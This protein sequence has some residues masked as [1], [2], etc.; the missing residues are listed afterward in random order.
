VSL[1]RNLRR[2][3]HDIHAFAVFVEKNFSVLQRE[4]R[5]V[6]ARA[7]IRARLKFR[8][9]LAD[10]DAA[11]GHERAAKFFHAKPFADAIAPIADAA[12]TFLCAIKI[13]KFNFRDLHD[14]Q[15][16]PVTDFFCD[17][18]CGVSV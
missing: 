13:L 14:S 7:D 1:L 9:A 17:S 2:F 16:L 18:L 15:F 11:R 8:P 6:A 10:D 4:Q 12:L 3:R 5:P